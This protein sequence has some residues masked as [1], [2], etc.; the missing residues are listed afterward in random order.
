MGRQ[1]RSLLIG[2]TGMGIFM[3]GCGTLNPR[4]T[5]EHLTNARLALETAEAAGA[6]TMAK[7]ELRHAQDTLA[8]A[9]AAYAGRDF[10]RALKFAKKVLIYAKLAQVRS[11]QKY[12]EKKL[13]EL[14]AEIKTRE[15]SSSSP[16]F[17]AGQES[18]EP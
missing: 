7:V 5:N 13:A 18:E 9:K 8:I 2:L 3:A 11:E 15:A 14:K 1:A 4:L 6:K 16:Q 17:P 10:K 12:A